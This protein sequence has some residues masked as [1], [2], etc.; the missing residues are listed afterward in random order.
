[1]IPIYNCKGSKYN[2]FTVALTTGDPNFA[3]SAGA[4]FPSFLPSIG[5]HYDLNKNPFD[6][7]SGVEF[8]HPVNAVGRVQGPAKPGVVL[9]SLDPGAFIL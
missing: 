2:N 1:M 9:G 3:P 5:R 6:L 7:L 8:R 4:S